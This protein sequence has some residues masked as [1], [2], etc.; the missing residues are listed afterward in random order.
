MNK[1]LVPIVRHGAKRRIR[2][3]M[4]FKDFLIFVGI[5]AFSVLAMYLYSVAMEV[6]A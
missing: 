3:D 1:H 2:L 4:T 6:I 5:C